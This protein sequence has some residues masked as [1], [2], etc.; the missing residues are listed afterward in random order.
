MMT[1]NQLISLWT[2][3]D[4]QAAN[5]SSTGDDSHTA[6]ISPTADD[7]HTDNNFMTADDSYTADSYKSKITPK[8]KSK[9]LK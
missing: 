5:K 7:S 4:S 9:V 2:A 1:P 6:N 3:D 8:I